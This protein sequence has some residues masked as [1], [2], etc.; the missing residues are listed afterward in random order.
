MLQ[1]VERINISDHTLQGVQS[2]PD[3]QLILGLDPLY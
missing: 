2:K 1:Q 3:T